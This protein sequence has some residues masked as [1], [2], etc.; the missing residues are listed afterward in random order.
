MGLKYL[1][2]KWNMDMNTG[3]QSILT[4]TNQSVI[5]YRGMYARWASSHR[6]KYNEMLVLY[7]INESGYCMQKQLCDSYHVPRQTINNTISSM[8][9]NG[10]ICVSKKNCKGREKA[11]VLTDEGKAYAT[12]LMQELSS[13]EEMAIMQMGV[14]RLK[15]LCTLLN[16]YH[17]ALDEAM[18]NRI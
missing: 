18:N 17:K 12:P 13:K 15:E 16:E 2:R 7:T 11:F 8:R 14:D 5:K 1:L 4:E 9:K 10:L 3:I 6:I